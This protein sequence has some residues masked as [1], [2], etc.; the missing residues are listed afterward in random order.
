MIL[1]LGNLTKLD[2]GN[3]VP[4]FKLKFQAKI[5]NM[6]KGLNETIVIPIEVNGREYK[7]VRQTSAETHHNARV[8]T[9]TARV[10]KEKQYIFGT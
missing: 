7:S 10:G 6:V 3:P 2:D 4:H 8:K 9:V 1:L 5:K